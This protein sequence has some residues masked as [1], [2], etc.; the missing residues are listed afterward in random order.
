[1]PRTMERS[2]LMRKVL[3]TTMK[4]MYVVPCL[5]TSELSGFSQDLAKVYILQACPHDGCCDGIELGIINDT[6]RLLFSK[7]Q[8]ILQSEGEDSG[9]LH[10][11]TLEICVYL[12]SCIQKH[13]A[14]NEAESHGWPVHINF[15][16]LVDRIVAMKD[17]LH[18][19]LFI[20][21]ISSSNPIQQQFNDDLQV[22]YRMGR[23]RSLEKFAKETKAPEYIVDNSYPG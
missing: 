9:V 23:T 14:R 22:V 3:Q 20:E 21:G 19:L 7:Y 8:A 17:D 18:S 1:M 11:Q 15:M 6:L 13:M 10:S 12:K 5:W 2:L 16:A 4:T